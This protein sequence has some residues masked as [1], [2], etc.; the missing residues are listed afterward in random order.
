MLRHGS[1]HLHFCEAAGALCCTLISVREGGKGMLRNGSANVHFCEG[2]GRGS[3]LHSAFCAR[4]S[5][6]HGSANLH[7][8]LDL[9]SRMERRREKR[10]K[11]RLV[12]KRES[13]RGLQTKIPFA[14][15]SRPL[16]N[17]VRF[18]AFPNDFWPFFLHKMLIYIPFNS[19]PDD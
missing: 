19:V 13:N 16:Q 9:V 15:S 3:V 2:A 7:F 5:E 11:Y 14:S 6:R 10:N 8:S 18:S 4:V 12:R 17:C 1:A